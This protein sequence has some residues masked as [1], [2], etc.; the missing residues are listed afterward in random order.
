MTSLPSRAENEL[1]A[2]LNAAVD[3]V[4][5]I[6]P[7]G[8]IEIFNPAAEKLFGYSQKEMLG[9]SV[10]R[11]MHSADASAHDGYVARYERTGQARIIG[12]GREIFAK[13]ANGESFRASLAVGEIKGSSPRRYVGFI[14]DISEQHQATEDLKRSQTLLTQA[15]ALANLGSFRMNFPKRDWEWSQHMYALTGRSLTDGPVDF[16]SFIQHSVIESDQAR[17][18]TAY[19]Q[20]VEHHNT[21]DIEFQINHPTL[22][23]RTLHAKAVCQSVTDQPGGFE[24]SG[25]LHD[26]TEQKRL[27]LEARHQVDRLG[28]VARLSTMGEMATGLA[29]E[30][31]QPL[32]AIATYSQALLRLLDQPNSLS[33]EELKDTIQQISVQALRAGEVIRRLRALIKDQGTKSERINLNALTQD[34]L[35]LARAD[36]L[37]SDVQIELKCCEAITDVLADP[38][39]IQQVLLNLVR[40]A[41]DATVEAKPAARHICIQTHVGDDTVEVAVSDHGGGVDPWNLEQIFDPFFTTKSHGTGLGLPISRSILRAHGGKLAYRPTPGGGA[42]FYFE[43]P[44]YT[45]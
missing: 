31:N 1:E 22:G 20:S 23:L 27:E 25:T 9:S 37:N 30:I 4:I 14:H 13:R 29:H 44:L 36:A 42:T 38:I 26:I 39:Q 45:G 17:T 18:L 43:L 2:L 28:H 21:L 41:I 40:N 8:C 34:L 6:G 7:R 35:M 32:T 33:N 24:F 16:P 3:A 15:E 19:E 5:V 12:R 10:T 11:L